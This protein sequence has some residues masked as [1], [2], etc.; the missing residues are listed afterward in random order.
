M[1]DDLRHFLKALEADKDF[2][3]VDKNISPNLEMTEIHKRTLHKG[4]P[5]IMFE[6][7]VKEDGSKYDMPVLVNLF[8]T[9]E[10]IAKALG[11]EG[12][13]GLRELGQALA[14]LR[15]PKPPTSFRD[16][17]NKL[18]LLKKAASARIKKVRKAPCQD[19][20][21]SGDEVNLN[22]LPIQT[23]WPGEPAPLITWGLVITQGPNPGEDE[24]DDYNLGIYR[25]QVLGKNKTLMRWLKH[26]GGAQ[27]YKRWGKE[28]PQDFPAA[29]V[30]GASPSVILAAVM[31]VPDNVSEYKFA[32][33]LAGKRTEVVKCKTSDLL[34]PAS[35]EIV[36]EGRIS[37]SEYG[38]E[39]PYGDHTGYYN[40][41]ESFPTFTIDAITMRENPIYLSTYTGRAPDEPSVLGEALNE[42]FIPMLQQQFPEICDFWLPPEG[43]SYRIAVVSIKKAYA[44]HGKRIMMGVWSYLRQFSYTKWVIVVDHH[45]NCRDWKEVMWAVST[46]MD[47]RRDI[48]LIDETPIDYLDFASVKDGLGSKAGLDATDKID[49]E[50]DREWGEPIEMDK[51]VIEKIDSI[52]NA[53]GID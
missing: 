11:C 39:G 38:D 24:C 36:L 20:V 10:R 52:W 18:P 30:I 32:G 14:A 23:C 49:A 26:R 40:S 28:K 35:A 7:P 47:P 8:G 31:P 21:L 13:E 29:V 3:R 41:V 12:K 46:K 22:D 16:A 34:V 17:L 53:L 6:N 25:M 37:L 27:Q 43:C 33:L 1:F 48:T 9:V 2:V 15:S 42:V 50:T 44:G 5:A 19:I 4:G 51:N 45:I